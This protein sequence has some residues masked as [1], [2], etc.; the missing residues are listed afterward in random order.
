MIGELLVVRDLTVAFGGQHP[1]VDAVSLSLQPGQ[2]L[3]IVGESGSG[4]STIA[5]SL[6]GYR[7]AGSRV[8]GEIRLDGT[9][10]LALSPPQ[11]RAFRGR[12]IAYVPQNPT[13][14]LNPARRIRT[15]FSEYLKVHGVASTRRQAEVLTIA[16]LASV[17]LPDPSS[18]MN[19]FPHQLSGGQQQRVVTALAISCNP[20]VL[21]LDEP[22]TG[23]DVSTQKTVL[24][25][26]TR[27]LQ[28]RQ[29][30]MVYVTHDLSVLAEIATHMAVLY[31]GQ[32]V[33]EGAAETV[34]RS[35]VHP[36][37]N[38]L[39]GSRPSILHPYR[40]TMVLKGLL[41]RDALPAG[42]KFAPRC[43]YSGPSCFAN[44]QLLEPVGGQHAAACERWRDL[45]DVKTAS[46]TP[47]QRP[48][49]DDR[50]T[51]SVQDLRVVYRM[52][53]PLSLLAK[54]EIV[55]VAGVTLEL[56]RGD[57]LAIVGES[58]S[59]KSTLAKSIAGLVPARSGTIL[60]EGTMLEPDVGSRTAQ[61]RRQIQL[62][63]QNPDASLNPRRTVGGILSDALHS[64]VRLGRKETADR[65][66]RALDE[67]RLPVS[68]IARYP[69]QLS[70]GERQRVAIARA[71]I[72]DPA[73]LICDEVL[74]ALDVSVQ[75]GI[76]D[77]LREL[78]SRRGLSILFIS[79]DLSVVRSLAT[80]IAVF[81][82]GEIVAST[83]SAE[84]LSP[85]FHPYL[86]KLLEAI[87]GEKAIADEQLT[88]QTGEPGVQNRIE[89]AE[90][91]LVSLRAPRS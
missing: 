60:L 55:A 43:V 78:R 66:A 86:R 24:E 45:L 51:L 56:P 13:T 4:K 34:F 21:V 38:A 54:N 20:P 72:V 41:L 31:A 47:V 19:R 68:Y 49:C 37:T 65:V 67:V 30:A 6:L 57:V 27:L 44:P 3:G 80:Q 33:E 1:I 89:D 8:T 87:P 32:V 46:S 70:G 77:L 84:L 90:T 23:L 64:F 10:V 18:L 83:T 48:A 25:V 74:S 26:L 91:L 59:G 71:L 82:R 53:G 22:T 16:A 40:R 29:I 7:H 75:A 85:P 50:P 79:H 9:D 52:T 69:K 14:A 12:K 2:L 15:M 62:I 58:G 88:H 17:S 35:P 81:Y 61:E 28:E 11:L 36:Y 76:L 5:L 73:I 39:L 42:C 63:F